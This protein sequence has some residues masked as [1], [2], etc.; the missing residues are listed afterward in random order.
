MSMIRATIR[1]GFAVVAIG[2][3]SVAGYAQ[4]KSTR[5]GNSPAIDQQE[6]QR[7]DGP[8]RRGGMRHG[9]R[10]GFGRGLRGLNLSDTQK[11]QI[12][13]VF[14]KFR[15]GIKPQ[16]EELR[17]IREKFEQATASIDDQ[18][19]A[20]ALRAQMSEGRNATMADMQ[21]IL[22]PEQQEQFKQFREQRKLRHE[23]MKQRRGAGRG[24]N[25]PPVQ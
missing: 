23:E 20:K 2:I 5:T 25:T 22:T 6:G 17:Q 3:L 13:T 11:Q 14:S 15:E 24:Q 21:A 16:M 19:R 1:T 18:N 4:E 8:S 7:P 12:H 9:G 10:S